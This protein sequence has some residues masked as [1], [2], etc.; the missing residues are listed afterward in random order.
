LSEAAVNTISVFSE[1]VYVSAGVEVTDAAGVPVVAGAGVE[2]SVVV[3][4]CVV[5]AVD[6]GIVVGCEVVVQPVPI[7]ANSRRQTGIIYR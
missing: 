6:G 1:G 7:A 3:T 4:G 5:T 2:T